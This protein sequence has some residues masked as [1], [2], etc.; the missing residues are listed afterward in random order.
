M[1]LG[2]LEVALEQGLPFLPLARSTSKDLANF[3]PKW[4]LRT[5]SVYE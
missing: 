4:G 5:A 1:S 2:S 3:N